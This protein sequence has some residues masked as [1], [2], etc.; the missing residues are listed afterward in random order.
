MGVYLLGLFRRGF[1]AER[2]LQVFDFLFGNKTMVCNFDDTDFR[3]K[4]EA[5]NSNELSMGSNESEH[6]E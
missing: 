5:R 1:V 6:E 3:N 2:G 4:P